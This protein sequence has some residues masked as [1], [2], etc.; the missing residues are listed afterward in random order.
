MRTDTHTPIYDCLFVFGVEYALVRFGCAVQCYLI[1][2]TASANVMMMISVDVQTCKHLLLD[3][4]SIIAY[5][6]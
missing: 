1:Y 5:K 4:I 6:L 3:I 2:L